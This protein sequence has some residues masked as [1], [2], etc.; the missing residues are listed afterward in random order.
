MNL[1]RK[2]LLTTLTL[3]AA[4][5]MTA[6]GDKNAEKP[7][8]SS[9]PATPSAPV[10]PA[11]PEAATGPVVAFDIEKIPVSEKPLGEFPFFTPP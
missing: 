5:L 3:C 7:A 6:C 11:A 9:A 2:T 10:T 1:N 4:L 8:P